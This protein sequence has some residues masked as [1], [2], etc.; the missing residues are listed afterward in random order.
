MRLG[1]DFA[2]KWIFAAAADRGNYP[3]IGF[4]GEQAGLQKCFPPFIAVQGTNRNYGWEAWSAQAD[5]SAAIFG[6]SDPLRYGSGSAAKL[7]ANPSMLDALTEIACAF[8]AALDR[9]GLNRSAGEPYE[10][11]LAAAAGANGLQRWSITEAFRRAGF[12]IL[13][14]LD[15][16]LADAVEYTHTH[17]ATGNILVYHLGA[18]MFAASV[19]NIDED[20]P[21]AIASVGLGDVGGDDFDTLLAELA[22]DSAALPQADYDSLS[23]SERFLLI[24]ECRRARE[25]LVA[26]AQRCVIDLG[27]VRHGYKILSVPLD[28]FHERCRPR[29]DKTVKLVEQLLQVYGGP[30]NAVYATGQGCELPFAVRRLRETFGGKVGR[31]ANG[32]GTTAIGLAITAEQMK[33]DDVGA[34]PLITASLDPQHW[35]YEF[36]RETMHLYG[37][38]LTMTFEVVAELLRQHKEAFET[39]MET[40]RRMRRTYPHL[41]DPQ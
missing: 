31:A 37:S 22:W 11:V 16:P 20:A 33:I 35:L 13:G 40:L 25:A 6:A 29:L 12:T 8:R 21:R 26:S 24:E 34:V 18:R 39:D 14:L 1:I 5:P 30:I 9:G 27:V 4:E 17:P 36:V 41:F 28:L 19:I 23:P 15:E 7:D 32:R 2:S 10:I 38:G 3:L